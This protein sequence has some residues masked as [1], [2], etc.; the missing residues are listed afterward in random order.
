LKL[1][2]RSLLFLLGLTGC[3]L[4]SRPHQGSQLVMGAVSYGAGEDLINRYDRFKRYLEEK[5]QSFVQ[6]EPTYNE[7]KALERIRTH[8]W[9]L[10]FS[11][12][13]LAVIAITQYQYAPVVPLEGVSNLR[14]V[15]VVKKDS[16]Y[17]SLASL[18][19]KPFA[20]G[21]PGSAT[22]Y[23]FPI[24]NLYGLTL[25]EFILSPTPKAVLE[26]IAQGKAAAGALSMEEFNT[27]RTQVNTAEFRILF[28]DAHQVPSG[29]ILL[30][31]TV[32]T[33][34]QES[35]RRVIADTPS[36]IADEAGFVSTGA[37]PDYKYMISAVQRVR[38]IFPAD[39]VKGDI[40]LLTRKPV[41]LFQDGA[42]AGGDPTPT[43]AP[44]ST[45]SPPLDS[46]S[47]APVSPSGEPAAPASSP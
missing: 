46:P 42:T 41:R 20:I 5:M 23:Y 2:R 25:S 7:T 15:I 17:E 16:P 43:A 6:I 33:N 47:A 39:Q 45:P 18:A 30:S 3:R 1:S 31:P 19:G 26:A 11:P 14:S 10:V 37:V 34:E 40:A 21:Q 9:G 28:T 4:G 22:G 32:E 8:A 13:G 24:F 35:I 27:F 38:S 44:E 29:V 36:Q 12:P